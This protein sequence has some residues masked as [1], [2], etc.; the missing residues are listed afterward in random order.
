T[1]HPIASDAPAIDPLPIGLPLANST[2]HLLDAALRP[3]P[4]GAVGEIYLGGSTLARGYAGSAPETAAAFIPD[5]FS[6]TP[7][8]RLYRTGDLARR[9]DNAELVFL[10]RRDSQVKLRGFRIELGEIEAALVHLEEVREAVV[11]LRDDGAGDYL[12]AYCVPAEGADAQPDR[13]REALRATLPDYMMP[14]AFVTLERM[15]RTP[16]DK[17]DRR[18]LPAP[19]RGGSRRAV[20]PRDELERQVALVWDEALGRGGN[21][22]EENFFEAGGNSLLAVRVVAAIR[23]KLGAEIPVAALFHEPTIAGLARLL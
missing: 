19:G 5:P 7:G 20:A 10:G 22:V 1:V 6:R 17:V 8:A 16:T 4:L 3:V 15:P 14:A 2:A 13:I 11:T 21:D 9:L 18:V 12:T 23:R